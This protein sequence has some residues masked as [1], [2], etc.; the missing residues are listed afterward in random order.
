MIFE[1]FGEYLKKI[2]NNNQVVVFLYQVSL[3]SAVT[4]LTKACTHSLKLFR[5]KHWSSCGC[6]F[7][8]TYMMISTLSALGHAP[9]RLKCCG[10]V[11]VNSLIASRQTHSWSHLIC[12]LTPMFVLFKNALHCSRSMQFTFASPISS[13][14]AFHAFMYIARPAYIH[15]SSYL[16]LVHSLS[17]MLNANL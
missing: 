4:N 8:N 6:R 2:S 9:P 17:Q 15:S 5:Q 11:V 13:N 3:P 16:R 10:F 12:T 14:L 1:F 7:C